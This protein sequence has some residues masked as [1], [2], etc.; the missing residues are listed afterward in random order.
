MNV[1]TTPALDDS[2]LRVIDEIERLREDLRF[3]VAE[4]RRWHGRLRRMA[5]ARAIQGSNSIE[6]YDATIEDVDAIA[7][8]E[9]PLEASAET[10]LALSGYRD[11]MTYVLQMAADEHPVLDESQLKALH[12]MMLKHDLDKHPGQWRPGA[13]FVRRDETGQIVYEGPPRDQ[14]P[15]LVAAMLRQISE[16][17]G[18]VLVRAAMAHLNLAMIHPFSDGN[19]RLARCL[20]TLVLARERIVAP[21]FASIEEYLGENTSA[22]YDVL[23]RVGEGSWHPENDARPWIRFCL[24][25]HHRQTQTHLKR[26]RRSE[27]LWIRCSA[28]AAERALPE[29]VIGALADAAFGFRLRNS[30]YRDLVHITSAE[31]ISELTASRDLKLL[32]GEGLLSPVGQTRARHYVATAEMRAVWEAVRTAHAEESVPD[33]FATGTESRPLSGQLT[34]SSLTDD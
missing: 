17:D 6:G 20:Q 19:G 1:F 24:V 23:A 18:P 29:R 12:F 15:V 31:E 2:E 22:Y 5:L 34:L 13:I 33:P 30:T 21:V 11:A 7:A 32:V 27:D 8:G 28:I 14:V 4:P 25:A 16:G 26:I 10:A 3:R 9:E